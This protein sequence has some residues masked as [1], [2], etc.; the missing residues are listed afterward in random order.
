VCLSQ[1]CS[2]IVVMSKIW[3]FNV[4]NGWLFDECKEAQYNKYAFY[5][6]SK[7]VPSYDKN[8]IA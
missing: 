6:K 7:W 8:H 5:V 1:Y 3:Q 4:R 2:I